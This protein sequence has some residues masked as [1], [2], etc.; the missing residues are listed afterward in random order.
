MTCRRAPPAPGIPNWVDIGGR[1]PIAGHF[2]CI[3]D[4]DVTT[5]SRT[6]R[7][8]GPMMYTSAAA[9]TADGAEAPVGVVLVLSRLQLMSQTVGAAL[10]GRGFQAEVVSWSAGVRRATVELTDIDVVLLLDDL[11]DRESVEATQALIS[12]SSAKFLVLTDHP[13]GPGWGALLESGAAALMATDSSLEQVDAGLALVR[14]GGSP[15]S[16]TRRSRLVEEWVAWLAED[17]QL[18]ARMAM[19]SPRE[20]RVLELLARGYRVSDI[21]AELGSAEATISSQIKSMRRKLEVGS[22]LAAVA[23]VHR[24][25]GMIA[26]SPAIPSPRAPGQ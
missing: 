13:E 6:Q 22:Q 3:V 23:V 15:L 8:G 4:V 26:G 1:G 17:D 25:G 14:S 12:R 19:L 9:T 20:R 16:E 2:G 24:L 18:R 7:K 10:R 11:E 21:G 5:T